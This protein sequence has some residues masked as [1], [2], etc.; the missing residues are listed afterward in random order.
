MVFMV[1]SWC[2]LTQHIVGPQTSTVTGSKLCRLDPRNDRGWRHHAATLRWVGQT[3]GG[4]DLAGR[5]NGR[6][7]FPMENG[8]IVSLFS[9]GIM[10]NYSKN[11]DL[12][13]FEPLFLNDVF[14]KYWTTWLGKLETFWKI[15]SLWMQ[16]FISDVVLIFMS[17]HVQMD[18]PSEYPSSWVNYNDLTATEPWN[19]GLC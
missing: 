12:N 11:L 2:F 18:Y 1:F 10:D 16:L 4:T 15:Q 19:H 9:Y 6:Q 13:I 7:S 17:A 3:D 14:R 8:G 5:T